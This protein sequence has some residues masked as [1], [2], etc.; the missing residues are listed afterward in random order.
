[1]LCQN[2]KG[3]WNVN[4]ADQHTFSVING[5]TFHVKYKSDKV[6]LVPFFKS[7]HCWQDLAVVFLR[8]RNADHGRSDMH[9]IEAN[10][11]YTLRDVPR[12]RVYSPVV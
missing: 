8:N 5:V 6:V 2:T 7:N 12:N 3:N 4:F 1:M 11:K 10:L 9:N